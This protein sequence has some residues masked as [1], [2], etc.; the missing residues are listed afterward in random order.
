[1][2]QPINTLTEPDRGLGGRKNLKNK[3]QL[4]HIMCELHLFGVHSKCFFIEI[5]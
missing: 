4:K 5:H 2:H 3:G 1:M